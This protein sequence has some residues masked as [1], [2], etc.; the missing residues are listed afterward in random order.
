MS[1]LGRGRS[2]V[3]CGITAGPHA[4]I[5]IPDLLRAGRHIRSLNMMLTPQP[6]RDRALD[7]VLRLW[8]EGRIHPVVD[9]T[10]PCTEAEAALRYLDV[11]RPFGKVLLSFP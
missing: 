10:F 8:S 4:T 3:V 2:L 9:R 7:L 11:E 5:S 1:V 6:V